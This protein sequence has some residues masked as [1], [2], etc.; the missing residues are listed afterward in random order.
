MKVL[1]RKDI[2]LWIPKLKE[3]KS[4][5]IYILFASKLFSVWECADNNHLDRVE[6][7]MS[8]N[9]VV[10]DGLSMHCLDRLIIT[11]SLEAYKRLYAN[12]INGIVYVDPKNPKETWRTCDNGIVDGGFYLRYRP[13]DNSTINEEGRATPIMLGRILEAMIGGCYTDILHP[14][15]RK[16]FE[17]DNPGY[18]MTISLVKNAIDRLK[19]VIS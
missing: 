11:G 6:K 3:D 8:E 15:L 1:T 10:V 17:N 13:Y 12:G 9:K 14:E 5:V 4:I 19:G 2:H 18:I 7:T 16:Y